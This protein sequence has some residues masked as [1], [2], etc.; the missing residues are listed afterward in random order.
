MLRHYERVLVDTGYPCSKPG[1]TGVFIRRDLRVGSGTRQRLIYDQVVASLASP[2]SN[3][4]PKIL[5]KTFTQDRNN[6]HGPY[7]SFYLIQILFEVWPEIRAQGLVE[8][9]LAE[10]ANAPG[11]APAYG[12]AWLNSYRRGVWGRQAS[13]LVPTGYIT[14]RFGKPGYNYPPSYSPSQEKLDY[15]KSQADPSYSFG[16]AGGY[17]IFANDSSLLIFHPDKNP[18]EFDKGFFLISKGVAGERIFSFQ[19]S[20]LTQK[21]PDGGMMACLDLGPDRKDTLEVSQR[22]WDATGKDTTYWR[23]RLPV[24]HPDGKP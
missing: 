9:V 23:V 24:Y 17:Q 5:R 4:L 11:L 1:R 2:A 18:K 8:A 16:Q 21:L 20:S 19:V 10:V 14:Q 3:Q 22:E 12:D 13:G 15:L 6:Y 7:T